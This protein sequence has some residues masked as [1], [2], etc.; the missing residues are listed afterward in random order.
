VQLAGS[1][2]DAA[3]KKEMNYANGQNLQT[4]NLFRAIKTGLDPEA[5]GSCTNSTLIDRYRYR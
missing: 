3:S 4:P 1:I 2:L 5:P